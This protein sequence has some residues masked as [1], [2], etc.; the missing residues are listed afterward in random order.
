MASGGHNRTLIIR[1]RRNWCRLSVPASTS[2]AS[3]DFHVDPP[4]LGSFGW[5]QA[6]RQYCV[7]KAYGYLVIAYRFSQ[8]ELPVVTHERILLTGWIRRLELAEI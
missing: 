5:R 8:A 7:L 3:R 2:P 4:G 1:L 6:Q